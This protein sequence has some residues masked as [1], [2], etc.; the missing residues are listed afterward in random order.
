M[1]QGAREWHKEEGQSII[2]GEAQD[3]V[4]NQGYQP[5]ATHE[6][7]HCDTSGGIE[8]GRG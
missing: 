6:D 3:L 8:R 5:K 2:E 7:L 4:I 1:V